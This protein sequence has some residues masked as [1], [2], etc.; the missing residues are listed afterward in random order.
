MTDFSKSSEPDDFNSS[1]ACLVVR[2][3]LELHFDNRALIAM[4]ADEIL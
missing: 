3:Q 2:I 1:L 4:K